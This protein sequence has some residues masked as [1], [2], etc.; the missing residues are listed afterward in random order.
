M[1]DVVNRLASPPSEQWAR[2]LRLFRAD[3]LSPGEYFLRAGSESNELGFLHRGLIRF[4]YSTPDG[5]EFNKTFVAEG[6]FLGAYSAYLTNSPARFSI[7]ALEDGDRKRTNL[8][9]RLQEREVR[10]Q[11]KVKRFREA[12]SFR[13]TESE[14]ESTANSG[15]QEVK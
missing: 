7:Q 14:D 2:F 1:H 3:T 15:Q 6:G 13:P 5:K 12:R 11:E 8:K 4:F 10:Y 9:A